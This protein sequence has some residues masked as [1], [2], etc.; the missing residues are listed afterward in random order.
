MYKYNTKLHK[1]AVIF[2]FFLIS[3]AVLTFCTRSS[4]LYPYN[5]WDDANS[6]FSMGKSMFH[7]S[8]IYRDIFD[9]KGPYLYF[10]YGLCSLVSRT[11]FCGVFLME[12]LLGALDAAA[13]YLILRLY[14]ERT[15]S[16][17]LLPVFLACTFS[18]YSFY[19]GGSAEEVCLPLLL[20]ALYILLHSR[21][22][23]GGHIS[24]RD[25]FLVGLM[26]GVVACI[27]FT[28]LGFFF[29]F[30]I[31]VM[32]DCLSR[33]SFTRFLK[34]CVIFLAGMF[35]PFVPWLVYFG[36]K[37]AL[38]DW[39][40]A[41]VYT[42][43]F[44]YSTFGAANKGEG[45]YDKLYAMAKILYWLFW[46]NLS[47]FLL[48]FAGLCGFLI[49]R[50]GKSLTER[51][52]PALLFGFSF[53]GIYIGG[54]A[55]PYYAFALTI[56]TVF[57]L[58]WAGEW[59]QRLVIFRVEWMQRLVIFKVPSA[60]L[61]C[62][63]MTIL[64]GVFSWWN[65]PNRYY[66]SYNREDVFLTSFVR[67]INQIREELAAGSDADEEASDVQSRSAFHSPAGPDITL[68]NYN[69]LDCGLYTAADIYPS[70][71]WF[72]TQT[73]PDPSVFADQHRYIQEG[74]TDFVVVRDDYP[75]FI[76][77]C[78]EQIDS[79]HQVMG[80]VEHDY[81]LFYKKATGS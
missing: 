25:V 28:L 1:T 72:Q 26:C 3:F 10:L 37:G 22:R 55:L 48:I 54:A 21:T 13:V 52:E 42:N 30:M 61:V 74:L 39:Y 8:V 17:L 76:F 53:L 49:L 32:I 6:Y 23:Y 63:P 41:Y 71:Y 73:N 70:C 24:L 58:I 78:Y 5:N 27:K 46:D 40:H 66:L 56:F 12:V 38:D 11:D 18:S 80:E 81:F 68:L 43:V 45:V 64:A 59:M 20:W 79:F 14:L 51:L 50:P 31:M 29:A 34:A 36:M 62:L 67:D 9:Q 4:F 19:W 15:L 16:L 2:Y 75:D 65:T 33:R 57:G 60:I 7:G 44:I 35:I 77:D 47:F 69:C